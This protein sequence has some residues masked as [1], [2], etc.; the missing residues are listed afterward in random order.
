MQE[1]ICSCKY[2]HLHIYEGRMYVCVFVWA[3]ELVSVPIWKCVLP[4]DKD[5]MVCWQSTPTDDL[6]LTVR[7]E[8]HVEEPPAR[9]ERV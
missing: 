5:Q 3:A 8:G 6:E 2:A 1:Y 4:R 9:N 7:Q